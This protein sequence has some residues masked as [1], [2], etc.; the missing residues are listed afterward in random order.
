MKKTSIQ[1]SPLLCTGFAGIF[2][3]FTLSFAP[4]FADEIESIVSAKIPPDGVVFE[5]AESSE[6]DL[7]EL[8]PKVLAA[9][10]KIRLAH[11]GVDFAVVSHGREE[12]ALQT[13]NQDEYSVVHKNVVSLV[14]DD[15]PVHVCET[16][17]G[18]YGVTSEDFPDYVDVAPTGPG[19]IS[20]YEQI[21]YQL[22]RI[23]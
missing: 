1:W 12:F 21:G 23:E 9:I 8:L 7:R 4:L 10:A 6:D 16:H 15:V 13:R 22:I 2:F 3:Y 17:A 14:N 5:I 19:Q 11:P 18:W 20:L